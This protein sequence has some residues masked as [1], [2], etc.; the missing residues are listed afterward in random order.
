M[1]E[2]SS[3]EIQIEYTLI[4]DRWVERASSKEK[5]VIECSWFLRAR[6]TMFSFIKWFVVTYLFN[7]VFLNYLITE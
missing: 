3:W 4:E 6:V 7:K 5:H 2:P 1:F